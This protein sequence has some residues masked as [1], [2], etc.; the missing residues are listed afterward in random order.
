LNNYEFLI[1]YFDSIYLFED[2]VK[3]SGG[4]LTFYIDDVQEK[5]HLDAKRLLLMKQ[6]GINIDAN[7]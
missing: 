2:F 5:I 7:S 6:K 1:L 3:V 4:K